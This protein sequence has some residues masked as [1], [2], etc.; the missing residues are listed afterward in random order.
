MMLGVIVPHCCPRVRSER[1]LAEP[2]GT[3]PDDDDEHLRELV[4]S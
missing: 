3:D 1:I 4:R 2:E